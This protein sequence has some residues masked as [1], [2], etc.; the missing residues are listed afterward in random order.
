MKTIHGEI[1]Q[2][3]VFTNPDSVKTDSC[4]SS[5]TYLKLYSSKGYFIMFNRNYYPF[6]DVIRGDVEKTASDIIIPELRDSL[7]KLESNCGRIIFKD[8][9]DGIIEDDNEKRR[10]CFFRVSFENYQHTE[11]IIEYIQSLTDS[12]RS[13]YF[14]SPLGYLLDV[15]ENTNSKNKLYPNPTEDYL[16]IDFQNMDYNTNITI[17]NQL[18]ENVL[19]LAFSNK[20]DVSKLASGI[21]FIQIG[22]YRTK[23]IKK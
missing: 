1:K 5:Y 14:T 3:E 20:I 9:K 6:Q 22:N 15:K 4:E 11:Q 21:Y 7:L 23:F 8:I 12:I 13:I 19:S 18:G 2:F 16:N 17:T 10:N